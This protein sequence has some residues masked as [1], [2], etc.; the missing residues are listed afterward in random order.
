[1][2]RGRPGPFTVGAGQA[3]IYIDPL[4]LGS[5]A[6][7]ESRDDDVRVGLILKAAVGGDQRQVKRDRQL[8]V[9]GIDQPQ[10]MSTT[11]AMAGGRLVAGGVQRFEGTVV[12]NCFA[13]SSGRDRC[14]PGVGRAF[15]EGSSHGVLR[16]CGQIQARVLGPSERRRRNRERDF[17]REPTE[18]RSYSALI[19]SSAAERS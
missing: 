12:G 5:G 10:P 6:G 19:W 11:S 7:R 14:E 8:D 15:G 4:S 13:R 18:G 2:P 9:Q 1:M 17:A 16:H 3:T